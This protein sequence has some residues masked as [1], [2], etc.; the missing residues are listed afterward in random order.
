[1]INLES[2]VVLVRANAEYP[3][4]SPY[5]WHV[6]IGEI[7]NDENSGII[8][9]KDGESYFVD[10]VYGGSEFQTLS[11]IMPNGLYKHNFMFKGP[12]MDI[13]KQGEKESLVA[14]IGNI[15]PEEE[16]PKHVKPIN[17]ETEL[18]AE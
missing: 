13:V 6:V 3:E 9:V 7:E 5:K 17:P 18:D 4:N 12:K 2:K 11:C 10:E 16:T 15:V 14:I 1:M 8:K